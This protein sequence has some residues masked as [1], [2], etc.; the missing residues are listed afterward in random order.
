MLEHVTITPFQDKYQVP[1]TYI[2]WNHDIQGVGF[3]ISRTKW[4][5]SIKWAQIYTQMWD[6]EKN[7]LLAAREIVRIFKVHQKEFMAHETMSN[8][9]PNQWKTLFNNATVKHPFGFG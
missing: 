1:N 8:S 2:W 4:P 7:R 3:G 6:F 9:I 5:T